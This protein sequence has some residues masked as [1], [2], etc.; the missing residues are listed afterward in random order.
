MLEIRS[1]AP[2]R[3]F[4]TLLIWSAIDMRQCYSNKKNTVSRRVPAL[5]A[6]QMVGPVRASER[7]Q[8]RAG[9]VKMTTIN[10]F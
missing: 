6:E 9:L 3:L 2:T 1:K 7:G 8:R 4:K 10:P 5:D